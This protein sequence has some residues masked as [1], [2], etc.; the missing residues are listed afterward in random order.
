MREADKNVPIG[1]RVRLVGY[2]VG[3]SEEISIVTQ[4]LVFCR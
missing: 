3:A 2:V 1:R 4:G